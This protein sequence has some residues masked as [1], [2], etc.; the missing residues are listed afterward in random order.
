MT[1]DKDFI[2]NNDAAFD[3][4]QKNLLQ[5]LGEKGILA[6]WDIPQQAYDDLLPVQAEWDIRYAAAKNPN[7]R[8]HAPIPERYPFFRIDSPAIR[9]LDIHFYDDADERRHKPEGVY[10]AE[11][12]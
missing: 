6:N 8:T 11:V 12:K 1:R 3:G 4:W 5:K 2:S 9:Y 7:D 10:G